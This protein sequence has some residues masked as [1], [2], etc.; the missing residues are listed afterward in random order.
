M[1]QLLTNQF[2]QY[3]PLLRAPFTMSSISPEME[4]AALQLLASSLTQGIFGDGDQSR[5]PDPPTMA[6]IESRAETQEQFVKMRQ[7]AMRHVQ[8]ASLIGHPPMLRA[9]LS[10]PFH[11]LCMFANY[12]DVSIA[13]RAARKEYRRGQRRALFELLEKRATRFR[14]TPLHACLMGTNKTGCANKDAFKR[15]VELLCG[16]GAKVNE[17]DLVGITPLAACVSDDE[18]HF[19]VELMPLLLAHG[20]DPNAKCRRG[21]S[22]VYLCVSQHN[23]KA[24]RFVLRAGASLEADDAHSAPPAYIA[25]FSPAMI[26][27]IMECHRERIL[28]IQKCSHCECGNATKYCAACRT[29]F[30]CS[31]NCQIAHWKAGHKVVCRNG[32]VFTEFVDLDRISE[33]HAEFGDIEIKHLLNPITAKLPDGPMTVGELNA[34]FLVK[35]SILAPMDEFMGYSTKY[36]GCV[37]IEDHSRKIIVLKKTG[38]AKSIHDRLRRFLKEQSGGTAIAYVMAKWLK[39]SL[40]DSCGFLNTYYLMLRVDLSRPLPPPMPLW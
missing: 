26:A 39:G 30:Y 5:I 3:L 35:V 14:L 21:V 28:R 20:A 34:S 19:K 6:E 17:R 12:E 31:R 8:V 18:D 23:L 13:I 11:A 7:V 15:T 27:V 10:E 37:R 2:L 36:A 40:L 9:I 38:R 32:R 25:L 1:E 22:V 16:A 4:R 24:L 29:A 33:L